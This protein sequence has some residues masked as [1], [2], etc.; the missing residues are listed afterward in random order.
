MTYPEHEKLSKV[1]SE[2]QTV[3]EFI[4]WLASEGVH[5]MKWTTFREPT[6]CWNCAGNKKHKGMVLENI[7]GPIIKEDPL[8]P[9]YPGPKSRWITCPDC[10]GT[11]LDY[12]NTD[13]TQMWAPEPRSIEKLLA[14]FFEIDH[15]KLLD[16][17]EQMFQ[18]LRAAN[19]G[20]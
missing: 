11:Q 12:D 19:A 13:E 16:E 17:K 6:E 18:A 20:R 9:D 8:Q 5:L 4:E 15:D 2:S 7:K 3:G 1:Q 14:A 10:G